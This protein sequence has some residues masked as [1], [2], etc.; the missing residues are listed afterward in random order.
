MNHAESHPSPLQHQDPEVA[1]LLLREDRRQAESLTLIASENHCSAA[2]RT[3]SASRITDKYAEGY[4][5]TRYYGGCEVADAVEDLARQRAMRLFAGAEDANVQPHS[6]TT[7]NLSALLALAGPGGRIVGMMLKAG[8]HLSHGHDRSHTGMVFQARQYGVDQTTGRIDL[9]E[10]R[11]VCK[12]HQPKVLIAGGSS[13]CRDID[14]AAF[15]AIARE[16]GALLL[17]DIA[18]PAGLMAAGVVPSPIGIADVVTMT[19]HK[20]LRGPR[21]GMILAKKDVQKQINSSVFPGSQGGPLVQQIAAK[22]VAF[23]EALQP[24]FKTYQQQVKANAAHLAE[25]L[26]AQGLD[27]VTGGTD[28]HIV[29]VDLRKVDVTGAQ[30]EERARIAGLSVNKNAVPGDARP[31]MVTSGLRLGTAAV[32]TRGFGK[33]EVGAIADVIVGLVRGSDPERFRSVV[34]GLCEAFPLP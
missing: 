22:A 19:T 10:V 17:A 9:D 21:G 33:N 12:E 24:Q 3:A 8:G 23:G 4:P 2:V 16:V 7:A 26:L 20:T 6:G 14:Y 15:A 29:L 5:G 11:K 18:H 13:Y 32:T 31:P 1:S 34:Q 25:R 28:N 27:L 30:V